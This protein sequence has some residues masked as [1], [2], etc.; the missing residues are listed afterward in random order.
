[1]PQT[2]LRGY[3]PSLRRWW[4]TLLASALAAGV[5]GA[6]LAM[7]LPNEY[8]ARTQLLVGPVNASADAQRAGGTLARTYA[9]LVM[10]ESFLSAA[11]SELDLDQTT[12]ELREEK[13]GASGSTQTRFVV[14]T[15]KQDDPETAAAVANFLADRLIELTDEGRAESPE[16][17]LRV[18]DSAEPPVEP[19]NPRTS[20]IALA[21]ALAGGIVALLLAVAAEY[22]GDW[23]RDGQDLA[24]SAGSTLLGR[25][26]LNRTAAAS[27]A[28]YIMELRHIASVLLVAGGGELRSVAVVPVGGEEQPAVAIQIARAATDFGKRVVVLV[29]EGDSD[30][31]LGSIGA[32]TLRTVGFTGLASLDPQSARRIIDDAL[33]T[34]DVVVLAAPSLET[35][36][37]A[38]LWA[39]AADAAIL[40]ASVRGSTRSAVRRA[41][42]ALTAAGARVEGIVAVKAAR[43]RRARLA[44]RASGQPAR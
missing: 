33:K 35:S 17:E 27:N 7:A 3:V 32:V 44:R 41:S 42:E 6:I 14:I 12:E 39:S 16:G 5:T 24:D 36:S 2:E 38:L 4:P 8:E 30:V 1:M 15:A 10:S 28:A 20:L 43:R 11:I 34:S 19:S 25:V 26:D 40:A 37:H 21:A 18:I 13:I 23:I 22:L 31:D 9:E 29:D